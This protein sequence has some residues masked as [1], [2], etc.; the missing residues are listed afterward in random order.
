VNYVEGESGKLVLDWN[1]LETESAPIV[2]WPHNIRVT[3]DSL[4]L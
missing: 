1:S 4:R 2:G 3:V